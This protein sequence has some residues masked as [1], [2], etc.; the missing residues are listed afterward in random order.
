MIININMNKYTYPD[1][2]NSA[3]I[4]IDVLR[5]TLDG[6]PWAI[7][8]T[9]AALPKIKQLLDFYRKNNKPIVHIVRIYK[10]DGSN[11]DLCR[12]EAV[13]NGEI[14]IVENSLGAELA[15]ELFDNEPAMYDSSLLIN[16]GVQRITDNEVIIYKPRWGAFYKTPLD[17]H[18][19]RLGVNTLVFSGCNFPNC[20]RTSIYEAS[21]RDYKVALAEDA[22]SG[23]YEQGKIELGNIGVLV[24]NTNN[25]ISL[26]CT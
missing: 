1:L 2:N 16:G 13:E 10:A 21:E 11:A 8:G 17:D 24:E 7:P 12:R 15:Q 3:L 5:D 4:T 9:S 20:P 19:K 18:L 23:L 26:A 22:I 14:S 6:Q 25:I